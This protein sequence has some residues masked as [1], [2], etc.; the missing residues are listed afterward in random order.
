MFGGP[1]VLQQP[2]YIIHTD[3]SLCQEVSYK[4]WEM[5]L[6]LDTFQDLTDMYQGAMMG[7]QNF[8]TLW[9]K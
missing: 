3:S 4:V 6:P 8:R 7:S 5:L 9:P 1:D 2:P